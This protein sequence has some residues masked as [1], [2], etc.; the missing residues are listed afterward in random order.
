MAW[1]QTGPG[2]KFLAN[3]FN[4]YVETRARKGINPHTITKGD[5]L[6]TFDKYPQLQ[7]YKRARF[8]PNFLTLANNFILGKE[9]EGTRKLG[10]IAGET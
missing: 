6:G 8:T 4:K 2:A 5:I 9:Q 3:K 10:P 7:R 1:S